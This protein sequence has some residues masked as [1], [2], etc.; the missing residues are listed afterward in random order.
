VDESRDAKPSPLSVLASTFTRAYAPGGA[1]RIKGAVARVLLETMY[2]D[3]ARLQKFLA[4]MTG[5]SHAANQ[6][7]AQSF[8]W[9][10]STFAVGNAQGISAA[11][12]AR[13]NPQ[14][15]G[16]GL[17][18][19]EVA[20]DL[21]GPTLAAVGCCRPSHLYPGNFFDPSPQG[22]VI[23]MGHF[24]TLGTATNALPVQKGY[25]AL[26]IRRRMVIYEAIIDRTIGSKMLWLLMSLKHCDRTPRRLRLHRPR[27]PGLDAKRWGFS[28]HVWSD[29][30]APRIFDGVGIKVNFSFQLT[31]ARQLQLLPPAPPPQA[32]ARSGQ[33]RIHITGSKSYIA[34]RAPAHGGTPPAQLRLRAQPAGI[35]TSKANAE[36]IGSHA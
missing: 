21:R 22:D 3:P 7:I 14:L 9:R 32:A 10:I 36:R 16:W 28:P 27:L 11:Q 6:G 17:D 26:A 2:A 19:P 31:S 34:G 8:P 13:F 5:I 24:C 15:T 30:V 29:L 20:A 18:L 4:S 35:T 23:L 1:E 25:D 12:I 33:R